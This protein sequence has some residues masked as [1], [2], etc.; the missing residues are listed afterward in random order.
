MKH[1]FTYR[2]LAVCWARM[3]LTLCVDLLTV[4][5]GLLRALF[6]HGVPAGNTLACKKTRIDGSI[7]FD[8]CQQVRIAFKKKKKVL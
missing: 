7:V 6:I 5:P 1:F 3:W 2:L 8:F 4:Q